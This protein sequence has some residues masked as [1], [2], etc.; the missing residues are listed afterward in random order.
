[1]FK[2]EKHKQIESIS[3]EILSIA[4]NRIHHDVQEKRDGESISVDFNLSEDWESL[5]EENIVDRGKAWHRVSKWVC[6]LHTNL[7]I[8]ELKCEK[9]FKMKRHDHDDHVEICVVLKG[10]IRYPM[11]NRHLVSGNIIEI[12]MDTKHTF[13]AMEDSFCLII[14]KPKFDEDV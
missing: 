14:Y 13:E 9:G 3:N 1:M 8:I 10:A 12:P 2:T 11:Q 6:N 4:K 5:E 7:Q